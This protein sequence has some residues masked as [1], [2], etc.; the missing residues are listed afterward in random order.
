MK[1]E[2]PP[3]PEKKRGPGKPRHSER[4]VTPEVL[5]KISELWLQGKS[6]RVIG[7][8]IGLSDSTVDHHLNATIKP[9][10]RK[11]IASD[12]RIEEARADLIIKMAFEGCERSLRDRGEERQKQV[13]RR[14]PAEKAAGKRLKAAAKGNERLEHLV[15]KTLIR[16][17]RD[18]EI[19]WLQLVLDAMD[20]KAKVAGL[21]AP[22]RHTMHVESELRVAGLTP[23]ELD[24]KMLK[25]AAD[26]ILE[27][28][29]HAQILETRYGR[30]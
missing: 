25:R 10:W 26:L 9:T 3:T 14:K 13:Q 22:A 7:Q 27:R 21:Y 18:G 17:A 20:F 19:G 4:P 12:A 6:S 24:E 16:A 15:E 11:A 28:Q 29:R 30:N 2:I 8:F 5:D 1:P 23:E